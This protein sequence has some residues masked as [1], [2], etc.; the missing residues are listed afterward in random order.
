ML[1]ILDGKRVQI[2]SNR[3]VGSLPQ[4]KAGLLLPS[5]IQ[6][7]QLFEEI[8]DATGQRPFVTESRANDVEIATSYFGDRMKTI[9]VPREAVVAVFSPDLITE[10]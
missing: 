6:A 5:G 1:K 10:N 9:R 2:D 8:K 3:V 4:D 7:K